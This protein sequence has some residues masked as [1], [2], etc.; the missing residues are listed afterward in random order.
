LN[1]KACPACRSVNV[2]RSHV[3]AS[4]AQLHLVFS[5]YR[6]ANCHARFWVISRRTRMLSAFVIGACLVLA[7]GTA[8]I[9]I[10]PKSAPDFASAAPYQA[11][12]DLTPIPRQDQ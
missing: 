3:R 8:L 10:L 6:C 11:G 4:E 5:P 2:R 9:G 1:V 12:L 7:M